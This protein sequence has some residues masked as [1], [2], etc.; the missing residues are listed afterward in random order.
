M[1][2]EGNKQKRQNHLWPR[3]CSLKIEYDLLVK[4]PRVI[5]KKYWDE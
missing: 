1:I 4:L 5:I 2:T 3:L